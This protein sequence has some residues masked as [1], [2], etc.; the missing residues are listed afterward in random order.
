MSNVN[1][2]ELANTVQTDVVVIQEAISKIKITNEETLTAAADILSNVKT[3]IKR[4]EDKRKEYVGPINEQVK[5]INEDFKKMSAP[6]L[7]A[8]MGIKA[9]IGSYMDAQRKLQEDAEREERK[10]QRAE[11]REPD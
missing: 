7:A 6:Y 11:E 2:A 8:E 5:A 1:T 10:R 4:L 9:L 3:R